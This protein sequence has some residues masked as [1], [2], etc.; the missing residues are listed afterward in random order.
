MSMATWDSTI[1]DA[2]NH[3]SQPIMRETWRQLLFECFRDRP[4]PLLVSD[5]GTIPAASMWTGSR[6]WLGAF[7]EIGLKAGDRLVI[8]LPP[9][10]AFLQVLIAGIWQELTLV[11]VPET[12]VV[13]S[14]L[15]Q[16]DAR[17]MVALKPG[18]YT[19]VPN[20]VEGPSYPPPQLRSTIA[21]PAPEARFM[22]Q[23]SGTTGAPRWVALSD[24]NILSVL[25][26][27]IKALNLH[28][29]RVLSV[30]PWNH[31]F[32][33]VIDLLTSLFTRSEIIRDPDGGRNPE[34]I[35]SLSK[36]WDVTHL[37][38]V[39]LTLKRLIQLKEGKELL[40]S[41]KGGVVGGAPISNKLAAFLKQTRLRTGYGQTEA[42][43]G[44]S[45]GNPGQWVPNFLGNPIGCEVRITDDGELCFRGAN[46]CYGMWE[47]NELIIQEP[48]RWV[49]TGDRVI[50]TSEGLVYRGRIND[51][52][53][54]ENGKMVE[55]G[56]WETIIKE[57]IDPVEEA[58]LFSSNG[59]N[60]DLL[61]RTIDQN[62]QVVEE[63]KSC[64]GSLSKLLNEIYVV[65]EES[66]VRTRKG[67]IAR[68]ATILA[69]NTSTSKQVL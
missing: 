7:R 14:I 65:P 2:L 50:E 37:S 69:Q 17:C 16:V 11:F 10:P 36:A 53:K 20:G 48:N 8:A 49:S 21:N 44:I 61:I 18:P 63:I 32:G 67:D 27:H 5:Y 58:L 33:L 66:W 1:K 55:A 9:S 23:T 51:R 28:E 54:L 6:I 22:L 40:F 4:L 42:S 29:G 15:Q 60:L 41:L 35:L 12:A 19:L 59:E 43:P 26:H 57:T 52:F 25:Y 34:S 68:E 38:A 64:L 62:Q 47:N 56:A 3:D 30:L 31:A 39:P 45:L 46:A 24:R 13:E